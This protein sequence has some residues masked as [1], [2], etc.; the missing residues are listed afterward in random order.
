MLINDGR[1][2]LI[3]VTTQ[4]TASIL[5]KLKANRIKHE[6]AYLKALAAWKKAMVKAAD[7]FQIKMHTWEEGGHKGKVPEWEQPAQPRSY[8]SSYNDVISQLETATNVEMQ[9]TG[10]MYKQYMQ[11]RWNW[12]RDFEHLNS[13]YVVSDPSESQDDPEEGEEG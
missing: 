12:R 3:M 6:A 7:A 10:D 13:T 2:G 5:A 11:D 9:L 1:G 4:S 8:V